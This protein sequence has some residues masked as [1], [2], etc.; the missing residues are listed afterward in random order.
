VRSGGGGRVQIYELD[1]SGGEKKITHVFWA[2]PGR[3]RQGRE[4]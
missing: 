3:D 4:H 2:D 1:L